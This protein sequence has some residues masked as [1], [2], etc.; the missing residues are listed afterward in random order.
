MEPLLKSNHELY[1]T[2]H[3][4]NYSDLSQVEFIPNEPTFKEVVI[5]QHYHTDSYALQN[6]EFV[7]K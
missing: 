2:Q 7:S 1:M 5:P 6:K 3:R 4:Q